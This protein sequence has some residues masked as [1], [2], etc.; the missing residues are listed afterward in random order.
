MLILPVLLAGGSGTRLWPLSR[1]DRPKQFLCLDGEHSLLQQTALRVQHHSLLPPLVVCNAEHRFMVA[2]QLLEVG[3]DPCAIILEP[4]SKNTA[5]AVAIAALWAQQ[6][7]PSASLFVTP[8]DHAIA[9]PACLIERLPALA[10]HSEQ[11]L[12]TFAIEPTRAATEYGYI[13][14]GKAAEQATNLFHVQHFKE[15]PSYA[16]AQQYIEHGNYY[17]NSGMF[18]FTSGCFVRELEQHQPQMMAALRKAAHFHRDLDFVRIDADAWQHVPSDSIDY[19]L[20][21][22]SEQV[23][24]C[25]LSLQWADLGSFAQVWQ[26]TEQDHQGNAVIGEA[27]LQDS[28]NNL[29]VTD[30]HQVVATLGVHDLAVV[31]SGDTTLVAAKSQLHTMPALLSQVSEQYPQRRLRHRQVFRPW[32]SY[33]VLNEG[34]GFKVKHI[35]LHAKTR[36][37]L[38]QHQHRAEHWVVVSGTVLVEIDGQQSQLSAGQST[39]IAAGQKHRLSNTSNTVARVIEVQSGAYLEEDDIVRFDD[40]YGR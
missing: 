7:Y 20:L 2:Q 35:M 18:M 14:K 23:L 11:A 13:L 37:S 28:H 17:W 40:D 8:A 16:L 32:G 24:T 26:H 34:P 5:A 39:F 1:Q 12:L 10:Q 15:K 9:N 31:Q 22:H 29:V 4:Q 25:P 38:Q 36:L 33:E 21:E 6:H 30:E 27:V 19:A 3:V